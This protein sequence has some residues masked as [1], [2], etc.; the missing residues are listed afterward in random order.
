M[1]LELINHQP[2]CFKSILNWN[3]YKF[4][5]MDGSSEVKSFL[6]S[7]CF[8]YL[9]IPNIDILCNNY[10]TYEKILL[11]RVGERDVP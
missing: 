5:F 9:A 6:T 1:R 10:S 7:F 4:D 8:E 3:I 2:V 11:G